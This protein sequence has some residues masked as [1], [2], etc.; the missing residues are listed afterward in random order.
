MLGYDLTGKPA[1]SV[2]VANPV[3]L[4]SSGGYIYVGSG[5]GNQV[6]AFKGESS[7]TRPPRSS[8]PP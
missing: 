6:L 7:P 8:A 2:A 3:H 4:L 5:S 1:G